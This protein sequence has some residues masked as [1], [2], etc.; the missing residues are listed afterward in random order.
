MVMLSKFSLKAKLLGIGICL[1]VIPLGIASMAAVLQTR[2]IT[3][4]AAGASLSE[5]TKH[6]E[7][8]GKAVYTL[9]ETRHRTVQSHVVSGLN[10]A[11][12][13]L[14]D[15]GSL[16]F[17]EQT[18]RWTAVNQYSNHSETVEL[19][20]ML[21]GGMSLGSDDPLNQRF[22]IV[23]TVKQTIGGTCTL[24]QRMNEQGDMLRI[25]TNVLKTD[26][27][28]AVNTYIPAVNPDGKPN[29][30][31]STVLK[32]QRFIGRAFVVNDWYITAYEPLFDDQHKVA[33][34]LYVG[35]LQD[36]GNLLRES[37]LKTVI[38][39]TGYVYVLNS[40]GEY[41]ISKEG[42]RDGE[43]LWESRDPSGNLFIQEICQKALA[44][45]GNELAEHKYPWKNQE[46][47]TTRQK[48]V[49]IGYFEPWDW[50]I[51]AGA[52]EDEIFRNRD[53][54]LAHG[55]RSLKTILILLL[56]SL[57]GSAVI[58]LMVARRLS[59]DIHS[60]ISELNLASVEVS[61]ASDQLSQS[62]QK[63]SSSATQHAAS[64]Q[65]TSSSME[66][67]TS[68][69]KQ[70]A[71]LAN[72]ADRL[73]QEVN[74]TV[75]HANGVMHKLNDSMNNISKSSEETGRIIKT[76]D[77]IAFQTNLLALNAAVEA[78]RAGESGAGFA[79]VADEVRSLA[80]R[81]ANAASE[82]AELI[83]STVKN[84]NEGSAF[85]HQTNEKF[86]IIVE[87]VDK[88]GNFV[89]KIAS[90][91]KQQAV[92]FERIN[93]VVVE[94]DHVV[95]QDSADSE[96]LA[97]AS[98]ELHAQATLMKSMVDALGRIVGGTA[99]KNQK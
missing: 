44:L 4:S 66:E 18:S 77:E 78:A 32:G 55:Q 49:K 38:G 16:G 14:K 99:E 35:V 68:M 46:E 48:I 6:L 3:A 80:M 79:V 51:G 70:N 45:N 96:E 87:G 52:Y 89:S 62:S 41:L 84:I 24:F 34:M 28:R 75:A 11:R 69:T 42:K 60:T 37:I 72:Q 73:T 33:G 93:S 36:E 65:E 86:K 91:S 10:V 64:I 21:V 67:M 57:V 26:G 83:K 53:T 27:A 54:L 50:V 94:M 61:G 23:D 95:Q 98:E 7:Q 43:N 20:K 39:E 5:S 47:N 76:I 17:S 74:Q 1:T 29:P 40:K 8:I 15:A 12:K 9:C 19:K 82:T 97:S 22:A 58:W 2:Q 25:S 31:V 90:A 63:I 88:V 30:V 59:K 56:V 71:D 92:T 85:V 81:A 13:V